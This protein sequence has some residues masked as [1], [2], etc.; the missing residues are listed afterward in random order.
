MGGEYSKEQLFGELDKCWL[1][2]CKCNQ[3]FTS[4]R[5]EWCTTVK[6]FFD[7]RFD[8]KSSPFSPKFQYKQDEKQK[9]Q[10]TLF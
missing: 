10:Q 2:N 8:R 9:E 5:Q 4:N 7:K 1:C 3:L 6:E